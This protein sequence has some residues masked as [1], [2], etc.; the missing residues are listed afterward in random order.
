MSKEIY[1]VS[2]LRQHHAKRRVGSIS[3]LCLADSDS[4]AIEHIT[5]QVVVD[6]YEVIDVVAVVV[7]ERVAKMVDEVKQHAALGNL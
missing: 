5:S 4:E 6:G 2:G 1:L 7:T 3:R